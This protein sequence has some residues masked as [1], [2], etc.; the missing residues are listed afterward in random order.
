MVIAP[1]FFESRAKILRR[2]LGPRRQMILMVSC[3]HDVAVRAQAVEDRLH[4]LGCDTS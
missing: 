2:V 1:D 4:P 3:S